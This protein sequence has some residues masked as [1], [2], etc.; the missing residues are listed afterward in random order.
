MQHTRQLKG[1]NYLQV[2]KAHFHSGCDVLCP[3]DYTSESNPYSPV[4][5]H[6]QPSNIISLR[7]FLKEGKY[8]HLISYFLQNRPCDGS[9]LVLYVGAINKGVSHQ[10][11]LNRTTIIR[12]LERLVVKSVFS[13][14][15]QNPF[16]RNL[17]TCPFC[18]RS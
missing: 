9:P 18:L 7:P 8:N 1:T 5:T 11:G 16:I 10:I 14:E 6:T 3:I 13:E 2:E 4:D 12:Q 17:A 15:E